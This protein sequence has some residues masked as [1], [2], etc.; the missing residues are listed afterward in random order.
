MLPLGSA[1]FGLDPDRIDADPLASR[2]AVISVTR[3]EI[4]RGQRA[5]RGFADPVI[6]AG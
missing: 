4:A 6:D 3:A 2:K 1:A 5:S